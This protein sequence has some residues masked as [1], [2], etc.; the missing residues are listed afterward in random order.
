MTDKTPKAET[1][2]ADFPTAEVR[3]AG[4]AWLRRVADQW[5]WWLTAACLILAVTLVVSSWRA[6]GVEITIHFDQGHGIKP[7]DLLRHRGIAVGEVTA[8]ELDDDLKGVNVR[9]QL[10]PRAADLAREKSRFWIERPRISLARVSGLETVVGAKFLGV[11]PGPPSA[12]RQRRFEGEEAP[13]MMLDS[14]VVEITIRFR[15]GHGLEVGDA[16]KY[17]GMDVGEVT[18]VE[19]SDDQS[20]V[21]VGVRLLAN[22]SRLARVGSQFWV[23]HPDIDFSGVRGLDTL[24]GGRYIAVLP[25]P[26]TSD[27]LTL[28]DGLDYAPPSSEREPGGLEIVL[29]GGHRSGLKRGVPVMYRGIPIG[30][31]MTVGLA[32]DATTVEARTYIQPAYRALVRENSVFWNQSGIDWEFGVTGIEF[33]ADSLASVALGAVALATPDLP[34]RQV[35]TGGRFEYH[36]EPED[37][38]LAWQPRIP[39]GTAQLPEGL[40]LPQPLRARLLWKVSTLGIQRSRERIGWVLPLDNGE[41]LGP[42]DLFAIDPNAVEGQATL[43]AAGEQIPIIDEQVEPQGEL[44]ALDRKKPLPQAWPIER[45]RRAESLEECLVVG[46]AG[47]NPLPLPVARLETA[48]GHWHIDPSLAIDRDWHGAGV[49]AVADGKL[50]GLLIVDDSGARV[51]MVAEKPLPRD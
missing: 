21:H 8:V 39:V 24:I 30:H 46:A 42:S 47:E 44:A 16:V 34:G 50:I 27:P 23:E 1:A 13:L 51:A 2:K 25:G 3:A 17:R 33:K 35:T 45:V 26:E 5:I 28:F 38:W 48:E 11:L 14:A 37:E 4:P 40:S 18:S 12:P 20:A 41:I 7:G 6:G 19:L 31:V 22:A 36:E 15:Q 43:E 29:V 10:Q 9:I 32:S 49:I